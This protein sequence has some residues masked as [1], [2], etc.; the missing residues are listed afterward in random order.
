MRQLL[1]V[2]GLGAIGLVL[3]GQPTGSIF[4]GIGYCIGSNFF[5]SDS[6]PSIPSA[7]GTA[8]LSRYRPSGPPA[9]ETRR[10]HRVIWI[11]VLVVPMLFVLYLLGIF[12]KASVAS[13]TEA[14]PRSAQSRSGFVDSERIWSPEDCLRRTFP[15][16][17]GASIPS[18]A[19]VFCA[20]PWNPVALRTLVS[21]LRLGGV[22]LTETLGAYRQQPA[23]MQ[24]LQ[25]LFAGVEHL[26][27]PEGL[28]EIFI[29]QR[30]LPVVWAFHEHPRVAEQVYGRQMSPAYVEKLRR[31]S[32]QV[33]WRFNLTNEGFVRAAR[34][35]ARPSVPILFSEYLLDASAADM[36]LWFA[37]AG[38]RMASD[39]DEAPALLMIKFFLNQGLHLQHAQT[40]GLLSMT[41]V[42]FEVGAE[43]LRD[44]PVEGLDLLWRPAVHPL[45]GADRP[46]EIYM[47]WNAPSRACDAGN[48]S[49]G[50]YCPREDAIVIVGARSQRSELVLGANAKV[51]H[52]LAHA[53]FNP[54]SATAQP[55]ITE[56]VVT[57]M[58]ERAHRA[59]TAAVPASRHLSRAALA[60]LARFSLNPEAQAAPTDVQ[61]HLRFARDW[62]TKTPHTAYAASALCIVH[63]EP[64][65]P[66]D[67]RAL[68]SMTS[69]TFRALPDSL[70][71]RAY[72]YGWALFH[73]GI[74]AGNM[75]EGVEANQLDATPAQL[76][77]MEFAQGRDLEP[78]LGEALDVLIL[79]TNER[80]KKEVQWRKM[81]CRQ[82]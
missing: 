20:Y 73:F 14:P 31:V 17:T 18:E 33:N 65:S 46:L 72:A 10:H 56:G 48:Y 58:G 36:A 44:I 22:S 28:R 78:S 26:E 40:L 42:N 13:D 25:D 51:Y 50:Q 53:Y 39:E 8:D 74:A 75:G 32:S 63:K 66:S 71:R 59:A 4:A 3:F 47:L 79:K 81:K 41:A 35:G 55:F 16:S 30:L 70:R 57:A 27:R 82:Q 52:E 67:V 77:A 54:E 1:W 9:P 64:M 76:A 15:E 6:P 34:L 12:E 69:Q 29:L 19:K 24:L 5:R 68:L 37:T 49:H 7:P 61:K 23:D 21:Q 60:D 38:L 2:L 43:N 62:I 80:V 45:R 11:A